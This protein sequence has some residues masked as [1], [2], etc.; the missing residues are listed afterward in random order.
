MR[1][2]TKD[3]PIEADTDKFALPRYT[4]SETDQL[5]LQGMLRSPD[6]P[7]SSNTSNTIEIS[8]IL[9]IP[10]SVCLVSNTGTL[11]KG[12]E[13]QSVIVGARN[14]TVPG[15]GTLQVPPQCCLVVSDPTSGAFICTIPVD[16]ENDEFKESVTISETNMI[17]AGALGEPPTISGD[18]LIPPPSPE[19]LVSVALTWVGEG[20]NFEYRLVKRTQRWQLSDESY[21]I[22]PKR[23][24]STT[25]TVEV[26]QSQYSSTYDDF[27]AQLGISSSVS[28]GWIGISASVSAHASYSKGIDQSYH[29]RRNTIYTKQLTYNNESSDRAL[30]VYLWQIRDT[31]SI[32]SYSGGTVNDL[33]NYKILATAESILAPALPQVLYEGG[34]TPEAEV[35]RQFP[36]VL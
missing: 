35:L 21:S 36:A 11:L 26:G 6:D 15:T 18:M 30:S 12:V 22:A 24:V 4:L 20:S 34:E 17:P 23:K 33:E 29:Y 25:V 31:L 5:Y 14:N 28:I 16:A 8:N 13:G 2:S 10:I 1:G 7:N 27:A 32:S 3:T 19:V 9:I